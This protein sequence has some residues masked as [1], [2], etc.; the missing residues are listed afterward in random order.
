[1]AEEAMS[2][3]NYPYQTVA[4]KGL[5]K[6]GK[7]DTAAIKRFVMVIGNKFTDRQNNP[8][9][10][11]IINSNSS[12]KLI[13]RNKQGMVMIMGQDIMQSNVKIGYFIKK[14]EA[15]QGSIQWVTSFYLPDGT[16]IGEAIA[17]DLQPKTVDLITKKDNQWHT[18][19]TS[20]GN[21]TRDIADYLIRNL[22]L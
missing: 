16:F 20:F 12:H 18:V 5:I 19:E 10:V 11:L 4:K 6:D 21:D 13:D 22:Y 7:T 14:S 17:P 2:I 9:T 8:K 3:G 1:M 15:I